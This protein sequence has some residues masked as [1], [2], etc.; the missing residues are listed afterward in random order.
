[1]TLLSHHASLGFGSSTARTEQVKAVF[2]HVFTLRGCC[3]DGDEGLLGDVDGA[4]L[5]HALLALLLLVEQLLLARDVAAVELGRD[6]LAEGADVLACDD[7]AADGGLH[8]DLEHVRGDGVLERGA[9]LAAALDE[10]VL[11]HHAGEGVDDLPVEEDVH[12]DDVARL[13]AAV[14]VVHRGVAARDA[15]ERVVEVDEDLVEREDAGEDERGRRRGC[16]SSRR[17][18]GAP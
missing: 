16:P 13:V 6:V 2:M 12:L 18:R 1:M 8:G 3:A 14:V 4:A 9:D 10:P 15:L 11:V 5:L 17:S 7:V